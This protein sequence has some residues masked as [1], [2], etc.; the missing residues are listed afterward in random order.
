MSATEKS[1]K[2]LVA[3]TWVLTARA[4]L[5]EKLARLA[6]VKADEATDSVIEEALRGEAAAERRS[7]WEFRR[8]ANKLA[9]QSA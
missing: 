2:L 1:L 8:Q 3:E 4:D 6:D 9:E 7:A 5:A